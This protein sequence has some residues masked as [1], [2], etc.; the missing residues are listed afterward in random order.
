MFSEQVFTGPAHSPIV[1]R[2]DRVY[3]FKRQ[4]H[5]VELKVRRNRR[6]H[7]ADVIELSAQRVAVVASTGMDVSLKGF[8]VI[9]HPESHRRT[10][11][12]ASL[13]SDEQV[14]E[15]VGRRRAILDGIE[16]PKETCA[17]MRCTRCE[18]RGECMGVAGFKVLLFARISDERHLG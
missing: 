7:E 13:L 10:V 9:E 12:M 16:R 11:R 15:L 17:K 6:V 5:L 18:Y 4:L 1:A 8:V 2:V 14:A 3:A